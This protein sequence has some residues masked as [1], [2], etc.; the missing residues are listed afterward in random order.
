MEIGC[1]VVRAVLFGVACAMTAVPGWSSPLPGL[2][3]VQAAQAVGQGAAGADDAASSG[4]VLVIPFT[5]ISRDAA[6]DWIGDGIAETVVSDLDTLGE[7]TVVI[8]PASVRA[9]MRGRGDTTFDDI[10]A[11]ALGRELGSRWVVTGGYQRLGNR[12]RITARLL[13]TLGGGIA[14]TVKV[15]GSFDEIFDLQDRIA[16]ELTSNVRA[17]TGALGPG[18]VTGGIIVPESDP[19][20]PV[21]FAASAGIL[22]G[23]PSVTAVRA[24]ESPRID[25]DLDDAVWQRATRITEFV[26]QSPIEGAP[27]TEDTEIFIAYDDT[28]L[29]FGMHAHYSDP[30]MMRANRVDRDR[31]GFGDDTISVYFDTFLDQQRA[32]VFT[33]N[34]YGVQGDSLMSRRGGGGGGGGGGQGGRGGGFSGGGGRGGFSGVPRGDSSWDALFESGGT[35]VDDGWTAE[36]AIP[37]KSLRYPSVGNQAHRWGFQITR[38][39]RGKDET[40]VWAPVSRGVSGFLPQMGLLDGM[41]GLSTSRNLEILPT[42]RPC[43]SVLSTRRP[44][45]SPPTRSP[46]VVS[47]SSTG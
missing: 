18:H 30:S 29:Y 17:S 43:R 2:R 13:D 37:F 36:M 38:S 27:A 46:K 39:I 44:A 6:D 14:G 32:Y 28:N 34:G 10:V 11:T 47:T 31:A 41:S 35:L 16:G 9:A 33:L 24:D 4:S 5:N 42:V 7:L 25:G 8:V 45:G 21:A 19:A 1:H 23:R 12:M 26:Q 15:D 3:A 22:T 40:V 20:N